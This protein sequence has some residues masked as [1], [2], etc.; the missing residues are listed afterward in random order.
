MSVPV[1]RWRGR[2]EGRGAQVLASDPYHDPEEGAHMEFRLTYEGALLGS[3]RT[4]TRAE[5]KHEIRKVFHKQLQRLWTIHDPLRNGVHR[6]FMRLSHAHEVTQIHAGSLSE[7]LANQYTRCGYRFVPL[8]TEEMSLICSLSILFLRPDRPGSLIRSGD[9][10][11]RLKTLF[12]AL[13][14]PQNQSELGRYVTPETE[15][16][17]FYCLLQDD[18]LITHVAVETDILL[19]PTGRLLERNDARLI[20]TV[21]I[22][23]YDANPSNTMFG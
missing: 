14:L 9:I 10:D 21:R 17:P 18:A 5:H 3:S 7:F 1:D 16:D 15:E 12:D 4:D 6:S 13:R 11:N 23:P 20:I 2:A 22:R 8:V 19:N